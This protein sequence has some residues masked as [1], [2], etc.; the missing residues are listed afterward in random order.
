MSTLCIENVQKR[1]IIRIRAC[2]QNMTPH[3][4][5]TDFCFNLSLGNDHADW[6]MHANSTASVVTASLENTSQ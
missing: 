4:L 2:S 3:T 5:R 1:N 6:Q